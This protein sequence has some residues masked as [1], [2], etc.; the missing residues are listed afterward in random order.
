[1]PGH[2]LSVGERA[3]IEA[4]TFAREVVVY[5]AIHGG[6]CA[7]DRIEIKKH[8][9]VAGDLATGQIV[10]EEGAHFVEWAWSWMPGFDAPPVDLR[11]GQAERTRQPVAN[12]LPEGLLDLA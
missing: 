3:Y 7:Y 1:M 5:G 8:A 12:G 11:V 4:E 10:I 6:L 2:R 9:S